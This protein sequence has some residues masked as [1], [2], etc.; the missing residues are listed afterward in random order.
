MKRPHYFYNIPLE[1]LNS[2]SYVPDPKLVSD[3]EPEAEKQWHRPSSQP[4]PSALSSQSCTLCSQSFAIAQ[5]QKSH[6]KSDWHYY[7]LKQK[8][9]SKPPVTE[10]EFETMIE[11]LDESLS[12]SDSDDDDDDDSG[13][14]NDST[15][16]RL[17]KKTVTLNPS[18]GNAASKPE[19]TRAPGKS[20]FV[21]L[22]SSMLPE[23]HYFGIHKAILSAD[24]LDS[25]S[26]VDVIRAKQLAPIVLP[27]PG[28]KEAKL[29]PAAYSCPHIF[30]CMTGGGHFAAM[31]L[32]LAPY[33]HAK[34]TSMDRQ[35]TVLAHK[36]FHKYTT[37]RQQG[38]AQSANDN[39]KGKAK[40][41]GAQ[42]RRANEQ[43]LAAD[44]RSLLLEWKHLIDTSE[45]LFIR[46]TGA[47]NK[48]VLFGEGED[49]VLRP[50]DPRLRGFPFST[51]RAT[52]HELMRSFIELTRLKVREIVPVAEPEKTAETAGSKHHHHH[53]QQS[54]PEKA[55]K[56]ERDEELETAILHTTQL[57][58]MIKRNKLPPVLAYIRNNALAANF[59]FQPVTAQA[60][61]L[62]PT[63]LHMAAAQGAAVVVTGLLT[64]AGVDPTV[65][66]SMGKTAFE[67]CA[68]R[69]VRDAFRMAR[70]ELGEAKWDWEAAKV[71]AAI[72]KADAERRIA[73]EKAEKD[74]RRRAGAERLQREIEAAVLT[75]AANSSVKKQQASITKMAK[76]PSWEE[77]AKGMTPEMKMRMQREQ[78]AR[79]AEER[80]R[81]MRDG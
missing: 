20:P 41:I 43:A 42:I 48:R 8:L 62:A 21:W 75:A 32:S 74:A 77:E 11:N 76:Y 45:L 1:I 47:Q 18:Y 4:K 28:S 69:A 5:D 68:D 53:H 58:S 51:K 34:G 31:V 60:N 80:L 22:Y 12:G 13:S 33:Q 23:N 56:P 59:K 26:L 50:K 81:R 79:A 35:A 36:T 15:L 44:I 49:Q 71:P 30:L 16:T 63:P 66:N 19:I 65:T 14:D 67:L 2:L 52:Q 72:S 46:A 54:A 25:S 73:K 9:R 78:R 70:G 55:Q 37:R 64:K 24:E 40:S 3:P 17:L 61:S 39:A 29:P 6:F 27:K 7:N 38:G 10:D 57:Q